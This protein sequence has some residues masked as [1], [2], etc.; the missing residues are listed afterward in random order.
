MK[1]SLYVMEGNLVHSKNTLG[2]FGHASLW[3]WS[4]GKPDKFLHN[5]F[6]VNPV[7]CF[8]FLA[9]W[10]I[11]LIKGSQKIKTVEQLPINKL[12]SSTGEKLVILFDFSE[13]KNHNLKNSSLIWFKMPFCQ[14]QNMETCI[15]CPGILFFFL[16]VIILPNI[17]FCVLLAN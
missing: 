1:F 9:V 12:H 8:F 17:Y 5:F 3:T 2:F 7:F 6:P 4:D 13:N 15:Y 11:P 16:K 14:V 10:I